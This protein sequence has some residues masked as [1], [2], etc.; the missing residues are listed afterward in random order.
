[1]NTTKCA[2]AKPRCAK[3]AEIMSNWWTKKHIWRTTFASRCSTKRSRR[4]KKSRNGEWKNFKESENG[5]LKRKRKSRDRGGNARR[6]NKKSRGKRK[7]ESKNYRGRGSTKKC[8]RVSTDNRHS[9]KT[10]KGTFLKTSWGRGASKTVKG[11]VT[12]SSIRGQTLHLATTRF[13]MYRSLTSRMVLVWG[14]REG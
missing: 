4:R 13:R 5:N 14:H 1:M 9:T 11:R 8:R 12:L 7:G 6:G 3:L 2:E 10:T